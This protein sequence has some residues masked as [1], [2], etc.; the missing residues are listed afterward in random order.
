M[1]IN[2]SGDF[3]KLAESVA[4]GD[5]IDQGHDDDCVEETGERKRDTLIAAKHGKT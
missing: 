4:F 2:D 5:K 3:D 1:T